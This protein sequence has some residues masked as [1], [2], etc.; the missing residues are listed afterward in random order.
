MRKPVNGCV[1]IVAGPYSGDGTGFLVVIKMITVLGGY[2]MVAITVLTVQKMLHDLGVDAIKIGML[3]SISAIKPVAEVLA[4]KAADVPIVLNPELVVKD[5]SAL[6]QDM[7][8]FSL[9]KNPLAE[10]RF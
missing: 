10:P 3:Y 5:G 2:A 9:T 1:L 6:V 7:A 8:V 4:D